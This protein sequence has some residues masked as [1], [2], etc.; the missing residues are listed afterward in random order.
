MINERRTSTG[1]RMLIDPSHDL[2][3]YQPRPLDPI[4]APKNVAVIG[5]TEKQG[6]V[7]RTLLWNLIS[8]PFGGTVFPINPNR[9]GVLG[10]KAYP[11]IAAV[12]DQVDL[13]IV[14]TPAP[15]VP[16]IIGECVDAGVKGAIVISAGFKEIGEEGAKLEQQMLEQARR[17]NMRIIGP[18]CLGVM[19]TATGLNAT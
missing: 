2:L 10:I 12:P 14:V 11:K 1:K 6:T 17:G 16:G 7:G 3:R 4:F 9:P 13:A 19:S 18:N 5:A 15:T 8:N